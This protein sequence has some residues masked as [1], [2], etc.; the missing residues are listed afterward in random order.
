MP[1]N[2]ARITASVP[3]SPAFMVPLTR[4]DVS[5]QSKRLHHSSF[6]LNLT[7][8]IMSSTSIIINVNPVLYSKFR[9][10]LN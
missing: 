2:A 10:L 8:H 4:V 9:G 5:L 3:A 7:V 6:E 1:L